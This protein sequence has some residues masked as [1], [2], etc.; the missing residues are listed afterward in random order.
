MLM[1]KNNNTHAGVNVLQE[2]VALK[3]SCGPDPPVDLKE[4][5]RKE[6]RGCENDF[7]S[8]IRVRQT[9]NKAGP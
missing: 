8:S 3:S 7:L 9:W 1:E 2:I 5:H 4:P 6:H